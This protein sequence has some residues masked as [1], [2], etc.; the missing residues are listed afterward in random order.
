MEFNP[1]FE[2]ADA[3]DLESLILRF[4]EKIGSYTDDKFFGVG[5]AL[6]LRVVKVIAVEERKV[7][8]FLQENI[9][10]FVLPGFVST[11]G[12]CETA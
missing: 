2:V 9:P 12:K 1:G 11:D 6:A 8:Y 4:E 10:H 3:S 7:Y 5:V